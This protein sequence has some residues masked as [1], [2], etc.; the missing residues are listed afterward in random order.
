[1]RQKLGFTT[2]DA[3]DLDLIA[4]WLS[5]LSATQADYSLAFRAL[6]L[7]PSGATDSPAEL[8][9]LIGGTDRLR[10][11]VTRYG[12]RLA[13]EGI[14]DG[15]RRGAMQR[16]NPKYVL[17]NYLAQQ[18]IERAEAGDYTEIERLRLLLTRPFDEQPEFERYAEPPPPWA[19]E[20]VVSCSS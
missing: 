2:E 19:R 20:L 14:P 4:E 1:M 7:V 5:L 12:A 6:A 17:R 8:V 10:E 11:W 9:R 16:T 15:V 13:T 18:A 3:A